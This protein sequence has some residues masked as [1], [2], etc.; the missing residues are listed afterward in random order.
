MVMSSVLFTYTLAVCLAAP[1][2][3]TEKA[4]QPHPLAPSLPKLSAK[5]EKALD[6]II[7]RFIQYEIGKLRPSEG[8]KVIE[9]FQ[10]LGPEATFALIRG[11]NRAANIEGSCPVVIIGK[12]LGKILRSSE[13]VELLQYARENI[14]VGVTVKRHQSVLTDLKFACLMRKGELARKGIGK[15][16]PQQKSLSNLT[17]AELTKAAES[18][19]GPRLTA[20]LKEL[21]QRRGEKVIDALSTA[22]AHHDS[23]VQ[24]LA[25]ELLTKNLARLTPAQVKARLKDDNTEVRSAA[26]RASVSKGLRLG[27]ELIDLLEDAD[28]N[29]RQAAR[30]ALIQLSKGADYGPAPDADAAARAQA[31]KQWRAWW[32]SQGK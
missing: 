21:A 20:V 23:D 16:N 13:D 1:E 14:G 2:P 30:Q 7:E 10:Q 5:E 31:V 22:A 26:A 3:D 6:Q 24:K 18:D 4:R 32:A 17:V 19:H 8:A 9:D 12:K 15:H 25:R 29:V 11:L 27:S 28:G